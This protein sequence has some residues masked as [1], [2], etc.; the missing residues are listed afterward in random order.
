MNKR[1]M[2]LEELKDSKLLYDK[3]VPAFGY[4]IIITVLLLLFFVVGWSI[5]APKIYVIK[6]S[7]IV[8]S[9]NKTYV[10]SPYAGEIA[11]M[12]I[13]E[14]SVV[15]VGDPLVVIESADM[16]LQVTQLEEQKKF[17]A[18]RITQLEKLV[19]SIK[20]DTNYFDATSEND[21]LYFSQFEAYKS[22]ILQNQADIDTFKAYG[23]S[24]E[25]IEAQIAKSESKITEIYHGAIQ[26]AENGVLEAQ[27][28][29]DSMEAQ[30]LALEQGQ[31]EYTLIANASGVVHMMSDYKN[32]MVVQ[33]ATTIA[34]IASEQDEYRVIAYVNTSDAARVEMG[35]T[36]DIAITGL[37]QSIYGTIEG[38]VTAIDADITMPQGGGEDVTPY[39]KV[40]VEPDSKYLI[41]KE[42]DKINITNGMTVETRIQYDK[43]TYFNYVMEELGVLTR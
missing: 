24:E 39:I 16:N 18:E 12:Y 33:G 3:R 2:M 8:E 42:G 19:Q 15:E 32:G 30:L 27:G 13:E 43:V 10:M 1:I 40:E 4:M 7:G 14:G 25:Q 20:D 41:S 22:Q 38:R 31:G 36:V 17:Y 29:V 11:E 5:F 6:S 28:Q 9:E 34:S 37:N 23:Y 21:S 26:N 35:D